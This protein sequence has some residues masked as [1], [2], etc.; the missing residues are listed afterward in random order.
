MAERQLV[1]LNLVLLPT[2]SENTQ[3]TQIE[4]WVFFFYVRSAN[5]C[6]GVCTERAVKGRQLGVSGFC[7][8]ELIEN[9]PL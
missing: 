8:Q 9:A 4:V 7:S 2:W 5:Y 3:G 1:C 6:L